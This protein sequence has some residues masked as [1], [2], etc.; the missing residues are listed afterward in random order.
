[1]KKIAL[2]LFVIAASGAY[3]WSQAGTET[4]DALPGLPP[5]VGDANAT[6]IPPAETDDTSAAR[7]RLLPSDQ[8]RWPSGIAR[9]D[10][11]TPHSRLS[12]PDQTAFDIAF[13]PSDSPTPATPAG[14]PPVPAAP[15]TWVEVPVPRPRPA[16][17]P[18]VAS[19]PPRQPSTTGNRVTRAALTLASDAMYAD[20]N[21]TGPIADAYYGL[22]QIE[23]IV[24][25]GALDSIRVLRYPSDRRTSRFINRQ[26]LPMLSQEVIRAQ[27]ARVNIVSGATLTSQAFIRSL[28]GALRQA[29]A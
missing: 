8:P 22:V 23:A 21:Y 5:L 28:G 29:R 18:P 1:M 20:G 27:S 6:P 17:Q 11:T 4:M 2:S 15:P 14:P 16:D 9:A 13:A 12:P 19:E 26:A 7:D 24:R 3:V 10:S 25:N